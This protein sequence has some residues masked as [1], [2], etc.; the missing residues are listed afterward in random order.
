MERDFLRALSDL[1]AE[2]IGLERER[3]KSA[4]RSRISDVHRLNTPDAQS[5]A[6]VELAP[7]L[8]QLKNA[9]ILQ[10]AMKLA[11]SIHDSHYARMALTAFVES[12]TATRDAAGLSKLIGIVLALLEPSARR[13]I[14]QSVSTAYAELGDQARA[15][16]CLAL[17]ADEK[18]EV[19]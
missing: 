16:E 11:A 18:G 12:L 5:A 4:L 13:D 19:S 1:V 6:L 17:I 10:N 9:E 2:T 3:Q 8:A 14:L 7:Q 15:A